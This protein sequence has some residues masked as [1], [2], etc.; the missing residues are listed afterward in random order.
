MWYRYANECG[1]YM[2]LYIYVEKINGVG[3]GKKRSASVDVYDRSKIPTNV[4]SFGDRM[5]L[6]TISFS[7]ILTN[8]LLGINRDN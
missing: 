8:C 2:V 7:R 1:I 4:V 6:D 3:L 5:Q